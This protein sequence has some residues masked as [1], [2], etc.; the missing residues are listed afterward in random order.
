M[1]KVPNTLCSESIIAS[2]LG[3][4]NISTLSR[5]ASRSEA[6]VQTMATV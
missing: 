2:A 5:R 3:E 6:S 4:E 1:V